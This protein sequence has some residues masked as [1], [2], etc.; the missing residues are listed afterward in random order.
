MLR[1]PASTGRGSARRRRCRQ[2]GSGGC[3][4]CGASDQGIGQEY[5]RLAGVARISGGRAAA[6]GCVKARRSRQKREAGLISP[7][8]PGHLGRSRGRTLRCA[9]T[10]TMRG[11]FLSDQNTET[12]PPD[13]RNHFTR[14]QMDGQKMIGPQSLNVVQTGAPACRK[15]K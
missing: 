12:G 6:Q 2:A 3:R 4:A 7:G 9:K 5:C 11:R 8:I 14:L 15:I 10:R 1:R 13:G